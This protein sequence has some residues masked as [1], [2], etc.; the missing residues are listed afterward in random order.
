MIDDTV[1]KSKNYYLTAMK[2]TFLFLLLLVSGSILAQSKTEAVIIKLSAE[3][4]AS[5]NPS[6]LDKLK[7]LLDDR[8]I[9]IHSNGMTETKADMIQHIKEG[10]WMLHKVDSRE[11]N[12]RVYK[13]NFAVLTAKGI[14]HATNEGKDMDVDL[15]YTEVWTHVKDGWLL[16]SRHASKN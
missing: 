16:A 1:M 8:M 5:M 11:V 15:Y 13:N 9:F 4:Y 12:V 6:S 3:K 7:T 10:K 2:S 14:F